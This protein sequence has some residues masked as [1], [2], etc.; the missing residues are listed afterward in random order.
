M[1]EVEMKII[2]IVYSTDDRTVDL[3]SVS[4]SSIISN[5]NKKNEYHIYI[6]YSRLSKKNINTRK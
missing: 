2:P 3:C 1:E 6:F 5:V 4:I